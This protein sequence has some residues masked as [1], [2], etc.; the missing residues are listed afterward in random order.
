[1][2]IREYAEH[3]LKEHG[4]NEYTYGGADSAHV[5]D[6][7]KEAYPYGMEYGFSWVDVAN[8]ILEM[9]KPEPIKRSPYRVI[10]D[11]DN[12]CDGYDCES[13]EQAKC[14]ALDTLINWEIE[15]MDEFSD[16]ENPTEDDRDNFDYM[17]YNCSVSV[18]EYNPATDEYDEVWIPSDEDCRKIGW[19]ES[20]DWK[21]FPA[22]I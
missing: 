3:I 15:T 20:G 14:D 19:I 12:F 17:V 22:E 2:T 21:S 6:D 18:A 8:A 4:C 13:F 1:M 9:S 11:T 5:L 7:I 10:Y 16:P